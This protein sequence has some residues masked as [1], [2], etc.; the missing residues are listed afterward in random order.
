M[1]DEIKRKTLVSVEVKADGDDAG[2]VIAHFAAFN[3]PDRDQEITR[4]GAF[5]NQKVLLGAYGHAS[6]GM[7][8]A[9]SLPVG[10]GEIHEEKGLAVFEGQFNLNMVAGRETFEAVK[11]AGDLQEWSYGFRVLKESVEHINNRPFR[12]L[13]ELAVHEVSPVMVGAANNSETVT[14][15]SHSNLSLEDHSEAALAA[16]EEYLER[17]KSLAGLRLSE[18]RG[19]SAA[20]VSRLQAFAAKCA[21]ADAEIKRLLEAEP[22]NQDAARAAYV[23]YL[24]I[25]SHLLGAA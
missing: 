1:P 18:G 7:F 9:P 3:E 24:R 12:V 19:L 6:T 15:K 17:V 21:N 14:I 20:H 13:E 16:V 4:T 2:T 10:R 22:E 11:D 8:G 23:A 5:G 25:Q